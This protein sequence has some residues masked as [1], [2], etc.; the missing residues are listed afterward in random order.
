MMVHKIV[1]YFTLCIDILKRFVILNEPHHGNFKDFLILTI[2]PTATS[3]NSLTQALRH[4]GNKRRVKFNGGRFKQDKITFT[5][6]TIVNI[7]TVYE[8]RFS[9]SNNNNYPTLENSLFGAVKLI[10]NLV[11]EK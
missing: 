10:I 7:Y 9:D 11:I 3:D 2:K 5:R 1:Q 4:I 6:G 8:I